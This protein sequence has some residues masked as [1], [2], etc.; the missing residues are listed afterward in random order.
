LDTASQSG[1]LRDLSHVRS[2]QKIF[3]SIYEEPAISLDYVWPRAVGPGRSEPT[4]CDWVYMCRGSRRLLTIWIPLIDV[5]LERGPL[6]ILENSHHPNSLTRSYLKIDADRLGVLEGVRFRHGR[7]MK[8]ASYSKRPDRV[9]AE[10][11]T[12]WLTEDFGLG[13]VVIFDPRTLHTTLDNQTEGLRL[14]VDMRFQPATETMDPRFVGTR[15]LAHSQRQKS[16]FYYLSRIRRALRAI[17]EPTQRAL[18]KLE[19]QSS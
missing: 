14:S 10:F 1:E 13:D 8:G 3:S 9:R 15:P 6:M 2:L 4:H 16:I 18:Q 5:P 11:G 7:L 12:R 19:R 17:H